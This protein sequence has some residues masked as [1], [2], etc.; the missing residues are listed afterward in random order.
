MDDNR[1][2]IGCVVMAAGRSSR[3]GGNKL[4]TGYKGLSLFRR[5]LDAV[6]AETL[7]RIVVVT[8]FPEIQARAEAMGFDVAW[9]SC[10][11]KG[12][13]YTIRLGLMHMREMGAVLFMVCDQP[14]LKRSSV[15]A[16]VE[17]YREHPDRIVCVSYGGQRGNPCIFPSKYY[18]QLNA[19][20]GD[21]GGGVVIRKHEEDLLLFEL[22]DI[23]ELKDIDHMSDV[24]EMEFS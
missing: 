23:S 17:H 22:S 20:T 12:I 9:N 16:A 1:I 13:S 15:S 5:A 2:K 11:E 7:D 24:E 14:M 3:F 10:P 6:P 8:R 21:E 19:L 4:L 18:L